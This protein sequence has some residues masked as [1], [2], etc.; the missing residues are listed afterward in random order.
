MKK[1]KA[2][3]S[4]LLL[5]LSLGSISAEG[6]DIKVGETKDEKVNVTLGGR[7][8]LDEAVYF[9]DVTP[10]GNGV[11]VPD[12]RLSMKATYKKWDFKIDMG[13]NDKKV[14]P[15]DIHARYNFN[16]HSW[17]RIGHMG[18]QFGNEGWET[19]AW[20]RFVAP[21]ISDQVFTL[22]RMV[23]VAYMNWNEKLYN[24]VGVFADPD[25][26][27]NSKE[28]DQGFL[29]INK[30][31]YTPLNDK[32]GTVFHVGASGYF[33]TGNRDGF[34]T[35]KKTEYVLPMSANLNTKVSKLKSIGIDLDNV[36]YQVTY[37]LEGLV[38][39]G[40]G[41]LQGEYYHTNVK[42]KHGLDSYQANGFYVMG[43]LLLFGD[44]SYKYS[45]DERKLG[46]A[47]KNTL[48]LI[49]RYNYTD[50]NDSHG[51]GLL[52]GGRMSDISVGLNYYMNKYMAVKLD[53]SY[54]ALG[55]HNKLSPTGEKEN[56]QVLQGRFMVIF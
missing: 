13:F 28:G 19:S 34:N 16:N 7:F 51:K 36:D 23:G 46:H 11:S 50:M 32:K 9:D 54:M 55:K 29:V 38:S 53:Y 5:T 40:I 6:F 10:I 49:A 47:E 56:V 33:R 31:N 12:L 41:F 21:A 42:R 48:E 18:P 22:P 45:M 25:A 30:F 1:L 24:T 8:Y 14:N 4:T 43:G 44:K 3:I 52:N 26:I 35:D 17:L 15:K 39:K 2:Y 27:S 20:M 37:V